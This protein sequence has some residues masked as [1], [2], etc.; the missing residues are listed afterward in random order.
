MTPDERRMAK[1]GE[2][3]KFFEANKCNPLNT[4]ILNAASETGL[5]SKRSS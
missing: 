2:V 5:N 3:V 1:Y 4:Q